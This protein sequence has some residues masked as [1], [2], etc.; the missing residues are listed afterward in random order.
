MS[1]AAALV[2]CLVTSASLASC[3]LP[4]DGPIRGWEDVSRYCFPPESVPD[5]RHSALGVPLPEDLPP[6]V[7]IETVELV[8]PDGITIGTSSLIPVHQDAEGVW[9]TL[10][11][12][13][14]PP[15][16]NFPAEWEQAVPAIGEPVQ[17]DTPKALVVELRLD[18]GRDRGSVDGVRITYT[19]NGRTYL[20]VFNVGAGLGTCE[21]EE[22]TDEE[23]V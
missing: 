6:G 9:L 2:L 20:A 19:V 7:R 12:E 3:R 22:S 23:S 14:F 13:P 16:A 1:R 21:N 10:G 11:L 18:D 17:T 5:F 8:N 15:T 4:A